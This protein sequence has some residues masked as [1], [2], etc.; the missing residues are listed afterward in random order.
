VNYIAPDHSKRG[1]DRR[2]KEMTNL[3][4][5]AELLAWTRLRSS[6]GN[7]LIGGSNDSYF[8][9]DGWCAR[10]RGRS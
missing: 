9:H 6:V 8:V 3:T 1:A 7:A 10:H 2:E 5:S 4:I